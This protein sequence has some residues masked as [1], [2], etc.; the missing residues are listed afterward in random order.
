MLAYA[1]LMRQN[2]S[3]AAIEHGHGDVLGLLARLSHVLG[4][5][6]LHDLTLQED[7]H[8][9]QVCC[10][11][12]PFLCDH[13]FLRRQLVGQFVT[14]DNNSISILEDALKLMDCLKVVDLCE[15]AQIYSSVALG[16]FDF[17]QVFHR[18]DLGHKDVVKFVL[19]RDLND[20]LFVC[21]LKD[22]NLC[23]S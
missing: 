17:L 6:R 19:Y 22:R 11:N 13:K 16:I 12:H 7:G 21:R 5:H 20:V 1:C 23:Q 18:G 2:E 8:R 3:I 15:D 9:C 14:K 10:L 4:D